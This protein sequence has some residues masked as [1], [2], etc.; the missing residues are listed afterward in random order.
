MTPEVEGA[1]RLDSGGVESER[2]RS[3]TDE[4]DDRH[5]HQNDDQDRENAHSDFLSDRLS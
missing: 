3:A 5:N 4:I 1:E 2:G